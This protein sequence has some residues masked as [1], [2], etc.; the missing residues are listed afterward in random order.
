M[1]L[2]PRAG[3]TASMVSATSIVACGGMAVRAV[4]LLKLVYAAHLFGTSDAQDAFLAAFLLPAMLGDVLAAAAAPALIPALIRASVREHQEGAVSLYRTAFGAGAAAMAVAAVL[5]GLAFP[6]LLPVL[7]AGFSS[8]KSEVTVRLLWL[9]LPALPL[10]ACNIVWRCVLNAANRF[11]LPALA[12]VATPLV[13]LAM[14]YFWSGRWGV[15][16]LAVGTVVGGTLEA[17]LLA[18]GVCRLGFPLVPKMTGALP[19]LAPVLRQFGTLILSSMLFGC[20]PLIDNAMAAALAPGSLS[21]FGFGTKL[22]LVILSLGPVSIATGALPQMARLAVTG[23]WRSMRASLLHF[24]SLVLLVT[25]PLIALLMLFSEELVRLVFQK[26]AFSAQAAYEVAWVQRYSL[27]QVPL[28]VMGAIGFRLA[29]SLAANELVIPSAA[30]GVVTAALADYHLRRMLGV[31][32]IALAS[33]LT[34]LSVL[35][36]LGFQLRRRLQSLRRTNS[37]PTADVAAFGD[38]DAF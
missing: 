11:A 13:S 4:G 17:A 37:A 34:Q 29:S 7:A 5:L 3:P 6:F 19:R 20:I 18:Y 9:L 27:L 36:T 33:V 23:D 2:F 32:G 16:V 28:A 35:T 8:A 30:V 10:T 25:I 12:P 38:V 14:L 26:G 1:R 24:G 22:A 15:D 31:Q 21:I